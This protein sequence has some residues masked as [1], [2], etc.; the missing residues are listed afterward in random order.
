MSRYE[1]C[2][3]LSRRGHHIL[4]IP[5]SVLCFGGQHVMPYAETLVGPIPHYPDA[6]GPVYLHLHGYMAMLGSDV[7]LVQCRVAVW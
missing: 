3:G 6:M 5:L 4:S 2:V 7:P 1:V